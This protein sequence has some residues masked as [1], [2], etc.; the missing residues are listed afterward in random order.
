VPERLDARGTGKTARHADDCDQGP[1]VV[2]NELPA[3]ARERVNALGPA[4]IALR[5][6]GPVVRRGRIVVVAGGLWRIHGFAPMLHCYWLVRV[7]PVEDSYMRAGRSVADLWLVVSLVGAAPP[8]GDGAACC[9]GGAGA[10]LNGPE[11]RPPS[12]MRSA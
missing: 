10:T 8:G 1:L 9:A 2:R 6:I 11:E 3:R 5:P 12:R 4:C 7:L